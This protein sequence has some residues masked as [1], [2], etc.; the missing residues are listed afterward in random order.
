MGSTTLNAAP[1]FCKDQNTPSSII[2]KMAE[3]EYED[4]CGYFDATYF[5]S[6][7]DYRYFYMTLLD[8]MKCK[9][10]LL[11]IFS[12]IIS[13]IRFQMANSKVNCIRGAKLRS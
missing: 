1:P 9:W 10:D 2:M 13:S 4:S 5:T 12:L 7:V 11:Y 6:T 3:I 8:A